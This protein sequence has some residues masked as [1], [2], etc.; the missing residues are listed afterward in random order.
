ME[1]R[2][3]P[4]VHRRIKRNRKDEFRADLEFHE[5]DPMAFG[6]CRQLLNQ[7]PLLRFETQKG[8]PMRPTVGAYNAV[9]IRTPRPP[10]GSDRA[11]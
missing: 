3:P 11:E 8:R 1:T 4:A 10:G 7:P 9:F 2:N 6:R 5:T